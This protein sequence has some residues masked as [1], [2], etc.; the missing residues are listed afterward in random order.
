MSSE[1]NIQTTGPQV[2]DDNPTYTPTLLPTETRIPTLGPFELLSSTP[3]D[4]PT[5]T[6]ILAGPIHLVTENSGLVAG[7]IRHLWID[8]DGHLWV[9]SEPGLYKNLD[10]SWHKLY[11]GFVARLLGVDANGRTWAVLEDETAIAAYLSPGYGD[12]L[13]VDTEGQVWLTT[14]RDDLRRFNPQSQTWETFNAVDL[15]FE[16][17]E[18]EE[19]QG[20]FLTDVELSRNQKV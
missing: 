4:S 2:P 9:A 7:N 13:V 14:G 11:A 8:A 20:H 17:V 6:P 19:Y 15:G 1:E 12:G 18:D 16:T 5:L 3:T 10:G